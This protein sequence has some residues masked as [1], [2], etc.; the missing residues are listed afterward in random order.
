MIKE[1]NNKVVFVTFADSKYVSATERLRMETVGFDF[2]ERYFLSEKD[3]P[4]DFFKGFSP[5]LYRRGYGYW[6]WKPY[7][8][9]QVL[10]KLSPGDILVYSDCG[11]Q[12]VARAKARFD[13]YVNM[14]SKEKPIVTFQQQH[15][16]K[17]W[18]KGDVFQHICPHDIERYAVTLQIWSGC[19]LMIKTEQTISLIDQW[20][21]IAQK[22]RDLFTD[23]VSKYPNTEFFQE[24]RHDQSC[25]SLLVKQMPHVEISWIEVDD[26]YGKWKHF[27]DFPIQARRKHKTSFFKKIM[28]R[29]FL[30]PFRWLQGM[31]LIVFKHFRFNKRTAWV[32]SSIIS[33]IAFDLYNKI[34]GGSLQ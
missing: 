29:G 7:V 30:R 8:V 32:W 10:E 12:W 13:Q 16:E 1:K 2:D 14:L 20:N 15:L 23:R 24:N 17:D 26:L 34:G 11:N 4:R 28:N 27:G 5:Q 6:I 33:S 19:F 9:K 31:Y 21:E 18:T 25:F 3:L 22:H